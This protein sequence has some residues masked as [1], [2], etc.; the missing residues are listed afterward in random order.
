LLIVYVNFFVERVYVFP[1]EKG[2]KPVVERHFI[3]SYEGL[4]RYAPRLGAHGRPIA[5]LGEGFLVIQTEEAGAVVIYDLR[6]RELV[7]RKQCS[8]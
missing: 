2:E 6:T 8:V 3:Y 5:S 7:G 1:G 4:K